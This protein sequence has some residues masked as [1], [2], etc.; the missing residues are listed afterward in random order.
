MFCRHAEVVLWLQNGT[1]FHYELPADL[2]LPK[3]GTRGWVPS[4]YGGVPSML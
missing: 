1:A 4:M 2:G 3:E